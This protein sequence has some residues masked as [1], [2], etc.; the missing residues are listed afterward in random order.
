MPFC[1]FRSD[2]TEFV[3]VLNNDDAVKAFSQGGN[4]TIGGESECGRKMPWY[5]YPIFI[6][7][8]GNISATAGPVGGGA[9]VAAAMQHPAPMFSYTSSKGE[10]FF[11]HLFRLRGI[12][13][14]SL[15]L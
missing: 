9:Q 12:A 4:V 1:R 5:A 10:H 8:Q 11:L 14:M 3:I 7:F 6:S 15:C 13:N 2:I